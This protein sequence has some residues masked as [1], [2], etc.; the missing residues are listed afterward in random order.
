MITPAEPV[1]AKGRRRRAEILEAA[2]TLLI[3]EGYAGFSMRKLADQIG[4]RLSN[5]QY[6]YAT[7]NAVIEALFEQALE[8]A[9]VE[10]EADD[11]ADLASL[12]HYAFCSQD[13]ARS[14]R[15][16]WELWALSARDDGAARIVDRFYMAYRDAIEQRIHALLPRMPAAARRR[17]AIL[18]MSLLEGLSLFR[19]HGRGLAGTGA[20]LDR[21]ALNAVLALARLPQGKT[22]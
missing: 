11:T 2:E 1:S 21:D 16:F 12:V 18:I 9:R 13:N 20:A 5:V 10:L 22:E 6:Y 4:I 14:C 19:G 8:G 7:P 17:R 3:E 15:L